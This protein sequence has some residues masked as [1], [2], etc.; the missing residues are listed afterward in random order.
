[1]NRIIKYGL[2]IVRNG[3]FLINKKYNTKMFLMPG[4]KPKQGESI[5]EC[6]TREVKEEHKV[7]LIKNS[8]K[9]FGDFED[10]ICSNMED[11]FGKIWIH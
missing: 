10:K 8:I 1:M 7:D 3:K 2:V 4:G 9:H 6:L 5:K 11:F